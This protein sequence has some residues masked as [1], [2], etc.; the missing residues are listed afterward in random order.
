MNALEK[1]HSRPLQVR[2]LDRCDECGELKEEHYRHLLCEVLRGND[3]G[4]ERICSL[5]A[6]N[7]DRNEMN[8]SAS[9]TKGATAPLTA[10]APASHR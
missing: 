10:N 8:P 9:A 5:P 2:V 6:A 4:M 7:D 3:R 1:W